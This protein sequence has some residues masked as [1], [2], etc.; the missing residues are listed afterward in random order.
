MPSH[1][2]II[3]VIKMAYKATKKH[4]F[5]TNRAYSQ[6]P[7][8]TPKRKVVRSNRTGDARSV[9]AG[10]FLGLAVFFMFRTSGWLFDIFRQFSQKYCVSLG[11]W[12]IIKVLLSYLTA[13]EYLWGQEKGFR[14]GIPLTKANS[15][16]SLRP[17]AFPV[18]RTTCLPVLGILNGYIDSLSAYQR[19][20]YLDVGATHSDSVSLTRWIARNPGQ[21]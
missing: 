5:G 8:P 7:V 11:G 13:Y 10:L 19:T 9:T 20:V 17:K 3:T 1:G 14:Q 2:Q 16:F 18:Y 21:E 15:F 12:S 6:Y 4:D